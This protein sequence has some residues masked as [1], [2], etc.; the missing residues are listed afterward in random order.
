MMEN[1]LV[2]SFMFTLNQ[3]RMKQKFLFIKMLWMVIRNK[4]NG[5][6]FFRMTEQQQKDFLNDVQDVDITFRYIGLDKK[7]VEKIVHRLETFKS[8]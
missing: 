3:N 8:E 5:W 2:V 4:E 6:M 7:V 1:T